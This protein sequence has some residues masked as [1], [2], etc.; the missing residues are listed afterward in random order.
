MITEGSVMVPIF[1]P[2]LPVDTGSIT[3]AAVP[4]GWVDLN[5]SQIVPQGNV[6]YVCTSA[7][8]TSGV[9]TIGVLWAEVPA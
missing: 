4:Q 7:T 3:T 5:G 8:L 6:G 2:V 9:F 1:V